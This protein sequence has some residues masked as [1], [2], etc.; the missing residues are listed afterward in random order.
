V[1]GDFVVSPDGRRLAVIG[2]D[3]P[4]T[5]T[6]YDLP[7]KQWRALNRRLKRRRRGT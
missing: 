7:D 6:A 4:M 3:D 5:V 1:Y 2:V